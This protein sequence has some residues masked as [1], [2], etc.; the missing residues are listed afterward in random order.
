MNGIKAL[1]KDKVKKIK[2]M[3][4]GSEHTLIYSYLDGLMGEAWVDNTEA[5]TCAMMILGDDVFYGGDYTSDAAKALISYIPESYE[6][7]YLVAIP[8]D[9]GWRALIETTYEGRYR[10]FERYATVKDMQG[11]DQEQLKKYIKTLP[12]G[13]TIKPFDNALYDEAM[14]NK[15][16]TCFAS[17]F[18]SAED[19]LGKGIGFGVIH[20]GHLVCGASSYNVYHG[21]IEVQITTKKEYRRK[22][23]AIACGSAL[24]LACL[25]QQKYPNW[26][27]AHKGSLELAK[28]LGYRFKEA[29]DAYEINLSK[30]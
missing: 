4:D 2:H 28:K 23:L 15:W 19:F 11:F 7:P 24:I 29:Y 25:E 17:N 8:E 13:Y 14:T 12:P 27:A 1:P 18:T 30:T 20:E 3:Y 26:D 16:S 5:P 6:L 21:G 10:R 22:G 9:N